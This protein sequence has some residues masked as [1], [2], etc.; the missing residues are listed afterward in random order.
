LAKSVALSSLISAVDARI[1]FPP[2]KGKRRGLYTCFSTKEVGIRSTLYFPAPRTSLP[3][4]WWFTCNAR[5]HSL[6]DLP[7][8]GLTV[9]LDGLGGI[10]SSMPLCAP[11]RCRNLPEVAGSS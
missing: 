6:S 5:G 10:C 9:T 3:S 4:K 7:E 8:S 11:R 2:R 1:S